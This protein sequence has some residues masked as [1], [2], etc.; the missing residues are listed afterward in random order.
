MGKSCQDLDQLLQVLLMKPSQTGIYSS[1]LNV[2]LRQLRLVEEETMLFLVEEQFKSIQ[3]YLA[4]S[5]P[6]CLLTGKPQEVKMC[7][8][9]P[10]QLKN[11]VF[12]H[13]VCLVS[14]VFDSH[15]MFVLN[16]ANDFYSISHVNFLST[17]SA[18]FLSNDIPAK[19]S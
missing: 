4:T 8:S 16:L 5:P 19:L 9:I 2:Q 14:L 6:M 18:N 11:P 13:L 17:A 7:F 10:H 12:F 3:H 15:M 1:E